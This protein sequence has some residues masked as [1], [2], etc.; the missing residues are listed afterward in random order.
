MTEALL[1]T[2]TPRDDHQ[3][4]MQIRLGPERTEEALQRAL[5]LVA[6]KVRV[7]GFRP[8]KAPH[9]AILRQYGRETLLREIIKDLGQ[10]VLK[11]ALADQNVKLYSQADLSDMTVDPPSFTLVL[12][13]QPAVELGDYRS[14]RVE[15]PVV[16][17]TDADVEALIAPQLENRAP[18][19]TVERPA[20][21][22]DTVI[23]DIQGTVGDTSM[24]DNHDW[25][26][27]LKDESGWLPGFDAAFIGVAAGD[28][29]DFSL[30]YPED[31]TSRFKGQQASFHTVVK[32]VKSRTTPELTDEL[33]KTLGEYESAADLRAK[34]LESMTKRR[35]AEAENR[36]NDNAISAVIAQA[37]ISYP[38]DA[39][40]D[41]VHDM[42]HDLEHRIE[43][44]G[45][46]LEDYLRL[47]GLTTEKYEQQIRPVAEQRLKGRLVLG[48]LAIREQMTVSDEEAQAECDRLIGQA[49]EPAQADQLRELFSSDAGQAMIRSNVLTE[50][51]LARLRAIVTG[52]APE[53]PAA[54]EAVAAP[55]VEEAAAPEAVVTEPAAPDSVEEPAAEAVQTTEGD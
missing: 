30:A 16:N 43:G 44:S 50:K 28:E 36:F 38:P 37:S 5:K 11:E 29:K 8:G 12:P 41:S 10:E 14:I 49:E 51:T 48:A 35:T 21:L 27:V 22:G 53:L 52:Q 40:N 46:K 54:A 20:A 1:I 6:K 31:S 18:W 25:E 7:P 3:L 13:L 15:A 42:V 55:P 47:Q 32:A 24:M 19:E 4:E 23:M 2:T 34:L 26:L 39:V 17:V 33:A 9:A 45:Y